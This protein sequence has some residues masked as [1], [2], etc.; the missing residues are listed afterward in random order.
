MAK[1]SNTIG[2]VPWGSAPLARKFLN[3]LDRMGRAA[4]SEK[5]EFVVFERVRGSEKVL[6]L[7]HSPCWQAPHVLQS[8]SN[9]ERSG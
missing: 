5:F 6:Q 2:S 9:G 7:V 4:P 3:G 1:Q 8:A